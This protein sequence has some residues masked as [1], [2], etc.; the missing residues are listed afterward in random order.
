MHMSIYIYIYIYINKFYTNRTSFNTIVGCGYTFIRK[1][2]LQVTNTKIL[3]LGAAVI[4]YVLVGLK[5]A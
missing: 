1:W 5:E 3:P 2:N 4:K